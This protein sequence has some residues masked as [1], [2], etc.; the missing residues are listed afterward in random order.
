MGEKVP[1][2][3]PLN[4]R[5]I[6]AARME[7]EGVVMREIASAVGVHRKTLYRWR[8]KPAYVAFV[9]DLRADTQRAARLTLEAGA[10]EAARKILQL[11]RSDDDRIALAAATTL[12]DRTGHPKTERREI[13]QAIAARVVTEPADAVID[14]DEAMAGGGRDD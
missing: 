12:L 3:V 10:T 2:L 4:D 7:A 13:L 14:L 6:R 9:R 11:V 8:D 1:Q 5:E